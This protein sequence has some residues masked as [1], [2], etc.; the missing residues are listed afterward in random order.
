VGLPTPD[1]QFR[2]RGSDQREMLVRRR[3]RRRLRRTAETREE[4]SGGPVQEERSPE[5]ARDF[6]STVQRG[7]RRGR[8][9]DAGDGG[10]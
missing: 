2:D 9:A 6:M 8:A 1:G 10:P 5:A 7:W 4:P 3:R